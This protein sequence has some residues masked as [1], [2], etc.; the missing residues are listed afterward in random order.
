MHKYATGS[1][2]MET[3]NVDVTYV[4]H[5][6]EPEF[7]KPIHFSQVNSHYWAACQTLRIGH[8]LHLGQNINPEKL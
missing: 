1:L 5:E 6:N 4:L 3:L 7:T 2:F 8:I